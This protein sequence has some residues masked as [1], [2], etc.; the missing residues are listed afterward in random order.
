MHGALGAALAGSA[1]VRWAGLVR[2]AGGAA[3][4]GLALCCGGLGGLG[5]GLVLNTGSQRGRRI[6][7]IE[8]LG[9]PRP[10]MRK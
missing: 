1:G 7:P 8:C 10:A 6:M 2:W 5:A 3:R 4:A 9:H